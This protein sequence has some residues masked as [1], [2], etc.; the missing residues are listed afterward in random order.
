M[1]SL[2]ALAVIVPLACCS[3]S[4]QTVQIAGCEDALNAQPFREALQQADREIAAERYAEANE[5]LRETIL[6]FNQPLIPVHIDDSGLDLAE[7]AWRE[8]NGELRQAAVM[9]RDI[10][11]SR[12]DVSESLCREG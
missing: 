12:I 9:R 6:S 4:A 3:P 10:L 1:R 7:A 2:S 8:R 11:R 5:I